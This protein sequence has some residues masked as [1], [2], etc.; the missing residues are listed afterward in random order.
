MNNVKKRNR[1]NPKHTFS[2]K[3]SPLAKPQEKQRRKDT[4]KLPVLDMK[5]LELEYFPFSVGILTLTSSLGNLHSLSSRLESLCANRWLCRVC[6]GEVTESFLICI[7]CC[8]VYHYYCASCF[9]KEECN[10]TVELDK[11]HVTQTNWLCSDCKPCELCLEPLSKDFIESCKTCGRLM[12]QSCRAKASKGTL[13]C[14]CCDKVGEVPVEAPSVLETAY[15]TCLEESTFCVVCANTITKATNL[16][17]STCNGYVHENCD[18]IISHF[19]ELATFGGVFWYSCPLCRKKRA[20]KLNLGT[21]KFSHLVEQRHLSSVQVS[22]NGTKVDISYTSANCPFFTYV[23]DTRICVSLHRSVISKILLLENATTGHLSSEPLPVVIKRRLGVLKHIEQVRS[24]ILMIIEAYEKDR[25]Q[26]E[27]TNKSFLERA[28]ETQDI[29]NFRNSS[30][31]NPIPSSI[32]QAIVDNNGEDG[33]RSVTPNGFQPLHLSTLKD[34][35][36][37]SFCKSEQRSFGRLLPI[38]EY[39]A[40]EKIRWVHAQCALFAA[41]TFEDDKG[42]IHCVVNALSRGQRSRCFLCKQCGATVGCC[43]VRCQRNYHLHCSLGT[44]G[45]FIN[46]KEFYCYE[47][48]RKP[49]IRSKAENDGAV[50]VEGDPQRCLYIKHDKSSHQSLLPSKTQHV[51]L[52]SGSFMLIFPGYFSA[53]YAP[54]LHDKDTLFPLGYTSCRYFW[55]VDHP[56]QIEFYIFH[57]TIGDNKELVFEIFTTS[58]NTRKITWPIQGTTPDEAWKH[59]LSWN[60]SIQT[61]LDGKRA[62]GVSIP[63][64]RFVLEHLAGMEECRNYI[65]RYVDLNQERKW[66]NV[67]LTCARIEPYRGFWMKTKPEADIQSNLSQ[68]GRCLPFTNKNG[69]HDTKALDQQLPNYSTSYR[70]MRRKWRQRCQVRKSGIQGLGLYALEDLPDDE[71]VIEYAGELI[72]PVIADIREKIYDRRKIGCY[73]FRLNDDFIVDATMKGNYARFINHS[74]EPNCL[75]KIITVDGDKQVI[76]IFTRRRVAAGEELTY[77]YQFEEFGDTIPCNCGARNCRGKMN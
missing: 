65:P 1:K 25:S 73:M 22:D 20:V 55:S 35:R 54:Y 52:R 72:R 9:G 70:K 32:I 3:Y 21:L 58:S 23:V 63:A 49:K 36:T 56:Q 33:I 2:N 14:P 60:P 38:F 53:E 12:H 57:V 41:E 15:D 8:D 69:F 46:D 40:P 67:P 71:F 30:N 11:H 61:K 39:S 31:E 50:S 51:C 77:D 47:H 16:R 26:Q 34:T 44:C 10:V 29:L 7:S 37:C 4:G 48:A 17:C 62:F 64:V 18:N 19:F 28:I 59:F 45:K 24:R 42:N 5:S 43:M 13:E 76:G 75:S 27:A 74:C 66:E 68:N 6:G